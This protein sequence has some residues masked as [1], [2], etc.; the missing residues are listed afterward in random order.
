MKFACSSNMIEGKTLTEKAEKLASWGFDGISVFFDYGLWSEEVRDELLHLE[1]RTGVIPCEFAFGDDIY[2][3]LMDPDPVLRKA[4]RE[5]YRE[6]CEMAAALGAVTEYEFE[7][8]PQSPLPLFHPYRKMDE[9]QEEAFLKLTEELTEPLKGSS[10]YLL[11]EGINR[12]ESPFLNSIRDCKD[13]LEKAGVPNTGVLADFFH[14]S[15]EENDI[16]D[17][18]RYAEAWIKHIHLGDNN[19]LLPGYG[20]TRWEE[21]FRALKEIGYDGFLNLECSTCGD[22]AETLPKTLEF[23]HGLA[24]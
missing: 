1:E 5:M 23:L 10:G 12:Y 9:A 18:I 4:S 15:I 20:S 22:P 11:L 16:P 8:G 21:S 3:H 14:M 7:Y 19:R 13:F 6:A 24:K 2:G 17:A